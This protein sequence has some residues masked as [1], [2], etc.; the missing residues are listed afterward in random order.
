M[1]VGLLWHDNGQDTLADKLKRAVARYTARFGQAP[2][3]C[4]VNAAQ[5]PQ[6]TDIAGV[7]VVPS[8][9]ILKGHLWVGVED[10]S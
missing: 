9:K 10:A 6:A 4:H 2:N 8:A 5:Y 3:V 1:N 7:R